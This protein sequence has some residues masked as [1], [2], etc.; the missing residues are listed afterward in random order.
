MTPSWSRTMSAFGW[1]KMVRIAAATISAE[2]FGHRGEHV[3]QEMHPAALPGRAEQHRRDRLR[4]P[5]WASEM[6]SCTPPSPRAFNDR[7]NPVQKAPSSLSPTAK[8][9]T[10][11]RPSA[12]TPVA[13]TTAWET[14]RRFTRA[15][16]YVASK[17]TYGNAL[18]G[19]RAVPESRRPPRRDRR[20]SSTPRTW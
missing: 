2:P 19:Q 13:I 9:S 4:S 1:A 6:T 7:R 18:V 20:R 10:S 16:Q 5:R 12:A 11:R 15:L 14:T 17:K 8:P 3:A